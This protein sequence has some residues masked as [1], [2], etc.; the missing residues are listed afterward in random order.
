M[1]FQVRSSFK[2]VLGV[3][4]FPVMSIMKHGIAD[5]GI[6]PHCT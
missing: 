1:L 2:S 4:V 6:H 3:P 5:R